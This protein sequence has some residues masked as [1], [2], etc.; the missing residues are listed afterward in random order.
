M[1][2]TF[3][4]GRY[5]LWLKLQRKLIKG[6]RV[7][8]V[9]EL[10]HGGKVLTSLKLGDNRTLT[11]SNIAQFIYSAMQIFPLQELKLCK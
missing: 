2:E 1:L 5:G 4:V 9:L 10:V 3:Q 11:E 8:I 7:G 6:C